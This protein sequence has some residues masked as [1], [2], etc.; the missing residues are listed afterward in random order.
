MGLKKRIG[1]GMYPGHSQAAEGTALPWQRNFFQK[2][3]IFWKN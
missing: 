1:T 3:V 2:N